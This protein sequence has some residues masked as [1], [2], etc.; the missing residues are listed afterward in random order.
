MTKAG[1]YQATLTVTDGKGGENA[2]SM[3]ITAGNEAPVLSFDIK[4]GNKSFYFPNKTFDYEVKVQD[5]EDGSLADGRIVPEQVSVKIDYLP[6]GYDK[7][8]IA[9]GHRSADAS[10]TKIKG[11]KFIEASDCK[12]CHA[13]NKKSIGPSYLDVA[14]KYKGSKTALETLTKKIIAGGSGVWGEVPMA[15]HPQL[16]TEDAAEMTKYILSLSNASADKSLPT[17]GSFTT[18]TSS[19]D[20][21]NGTYILRAAYQ[22]QGF[23]G[24]PSLT[25]EQVYTLRNSKVPPHNFDKFED[26]NKMTFNGNAFCIPTKSG[27]YMVLNQV[28]LTNIAILEI[29]ASAPTSQLVAAGGKVELRLDSPTGQLIAETP[30]LEPSDGFG[31]KPLQANVK[32]TEGVHD[33]YLVF[34]N[35]KADGRSL[36][37]VTGVEFKQQTETSMAKPVQEAKTDMGDYAGKYKM[38]GLPFDYIEF[39]VKDNKLIMNANGQG[40]EIAPTDTPDKYDADGKAM[41]IFIRNEANKISGVKMEAMGMSFEGKR[42]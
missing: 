29:I 32:P 12:A 17:K 18:K 14:M 26:I 37:V 33:V 34:V 10:A 31:G 21:G 36:M 24:I 11:L 22:D 9:Q 3:E 2:Q 1:V 8:E 19:K 42:E 13:Q 6:E 39:S 20:K 5:K 7:I 30:F 25:S 15:G 16:S 27:A 38:Q 35:P 4:K 41:V 28:D 23:N 40:G